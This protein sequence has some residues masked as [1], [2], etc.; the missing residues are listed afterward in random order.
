M[1]AVEFNRAWTANMEEFEQRAASIL[2]AR[3]TR[4]AARD[5]RDGHAAE[6]TRE[7]ER[8]L[9]EHGGRKLLY[10]NNFYDDPELHDAAGDVA[11]ELEHHHA[12]DRGHLP[13]ERL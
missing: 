6:A 11:D 8:W 2:Q 13:Q 7:L 4:L 1:E 9:A 5:A 3:R 12:V 10:S